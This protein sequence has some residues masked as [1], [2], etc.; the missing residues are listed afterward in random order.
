MVLRQL[1]QRT[2]LPTPGFSIYFPTF[3]RLPSV[4]G[5]F[6]NRL[7]PDDSEGSSIFIKELLFFG[8]WTTIPNVIPSRTMSPWST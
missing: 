1:A 3:F 4:V 8:M 2:F 6:P 7:L 5:D